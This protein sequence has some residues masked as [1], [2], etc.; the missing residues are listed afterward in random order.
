[1]GATGESVGRLTDAGFNP[2]WA[3]DGK[4]IVYATVGTTDGQSRFEDKSHLWAVD[5]ASGEKRLVTDSD[6]AQPSWSTWPATAPCR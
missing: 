3:P 5:V 4:E 6:A 1:M 2:A